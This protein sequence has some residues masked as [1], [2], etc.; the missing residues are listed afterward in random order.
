MSI[1]CDIHMKG[2]A[3]DEKVSGDGVLAVKI[4]LKFKSSYFLN[5][6]AKGVQP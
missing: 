6:S 1:A 5:K 2:F 4:F 3:C